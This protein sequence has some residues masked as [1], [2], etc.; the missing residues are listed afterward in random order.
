MSVT[1]SLYYRKSYFL[2]G[3]PALMEQL[4]QTHFNQAEQVS[5]EDYESRITVTSAK[6]KATE[7]L[8]SI[9]VGIVFAVE[10]ASTTVSHMN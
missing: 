4:R 3:E 7:H 6:S 5:W 1:T 8:V 2:T 9:S 10:M